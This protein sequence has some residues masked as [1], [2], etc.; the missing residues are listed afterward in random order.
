VAASKGTA[1]AFSG[2][3]GETKKGRIDYIYYSKGSKLAVKSSQ[4]YDTRD[5][6]GVMPSDHRPVL[7]TFYLQ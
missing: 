7:T 6:N 5:A 1:I 2:N 4:V 3:T